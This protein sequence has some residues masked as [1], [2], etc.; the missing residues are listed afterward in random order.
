MVENDFCAEEKIDSAEQVENAEPI[1]T[2]EHIEK[3][4]VDKLIQFLKLNST[5]ADK[6]LEDEDKTEKMLQKLEKK[7]SN[8]PIAGSVLAYIPVMVSL[9]RNYV[10]K[11]YTNIPRGSMVAIVITLIY[12]VSPIDIIPDI[13]PGGLVDD[14]LIVSA[15]LVL[16]KKDLVAY[17]AWRKEK[18]FE[19]EELPDYDDV[20]KDS[21]IGNKIVKAFEDAVAKF[22]K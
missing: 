15:C 20:A 22:K 11:E 8:I 6:I 5:K 7:L 2:E 10:K 1:D 18:G 4:V 14:A 9:V 19:Y 12:S 17:Q 13:L 3:G 21:N 16:V